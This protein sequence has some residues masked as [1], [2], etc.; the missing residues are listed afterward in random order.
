MGR[1]AVF[2]NEKVNSGKVNSG[3]EGPENPLAS[4]GQREMV[5]EAEAKD[6]KVCEATVAEDHREETCRPR[7]RRWVIY[8]GQP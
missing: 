3:V 7:S 6:S 4:K 1:N 2:A 8:C 5:A